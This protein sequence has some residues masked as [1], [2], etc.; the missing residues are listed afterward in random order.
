MNECI[1]WSRGLLVVLFLFIPAMLIIFW[2]HSQ[3]KKADREYEQKLEA[4]KKRYGIEV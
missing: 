2:V 1:N 4:I 3:N